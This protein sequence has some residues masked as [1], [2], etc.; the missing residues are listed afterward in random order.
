MNTHRG[1]TLIELLVVISIV[2]LLSSIVIVSLGSAR[3]KARDASIISEAQ[4]FAKLAAQ[5]HSDTGSYSAL[6][7]GWDSSIANCG[8]SFSGTYATQARQLCSSMVQKTVSGPSGAL[9]TGTAINNTAHFSLMV[10]LP[11]KQRYFCI[12]SSGKSSATTP[13]ETSYWGG[14]GCHGNP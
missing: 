11:G 10:W 12:G 7:S 14:P 9:H 6:Q 3:N 13:N 4:Q 1:F 5:N 8:D 2:G